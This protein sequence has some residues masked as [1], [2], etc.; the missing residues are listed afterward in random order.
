MNNINQTFN[1]ISVIRTRKLQCIGH[2]LR[3]FDKKLVKHAVRVQF[4]CG[5][6]DR[7]QK[8]YCLVSAVKNAVMEVVMT[9][10]TTTMTR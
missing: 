10:T 2:V 7:T 4:E 3:M 6:R 8:Q 5:R 1:I 9:V